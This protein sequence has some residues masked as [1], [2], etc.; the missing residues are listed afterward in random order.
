MTSS[1]PSPLTKP[2]ERAQGAHYDEIGSAYEQHYDDPWSRRYREMFIERR[3]LDGVPLGGRRVLEA[4]CGSGA[5]TAAL[6]AGGARVAGL[7]ISTQQ[8]TA[9]KARW[10]RASVIRGSMLDT[11]F[12][13]NA[14]D[15]VVIVGG[16]H[17]L[18]PH[19]DRAIGEVHRLLRPG[20]VFAFCEPH[21]GSWPDALRRLWYRRDPLFEPNEAAVDV[22][23]LIEK[24]RDGFEVVATHYGGGL[25]YLLVYNSMV[26]RVPLGLKK[27]YA[28]PLLAFESLTARMQGERLSCFVVARWRK[29]HV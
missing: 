21:A 19:V 11:G 18:Q 10:P 6:L 17:H 14:F 1:A 9:F 27:Y 12:A 20:G 2:E 24:H 28:G 8:V 23:P 25:A 29:R 5:A 22:K 3:L 16:L 7:D 13:S 4:M 26:F 15:A